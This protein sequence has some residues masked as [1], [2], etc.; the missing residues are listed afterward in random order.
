MKYLCLP[1]DSLLKVN[2]NKNTLF[3]A[4]ITTSIIVTL[5]ISFARNSGAAFDVA[6]SNVKGTMSNIYSIF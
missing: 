6:F 4:I 1:G 3:F 5:F 2:L